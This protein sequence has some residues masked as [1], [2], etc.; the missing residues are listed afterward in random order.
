MTLGEIV[1]DDAPQSGNWTPDVDDDVLSAFL[2]A[3]A[4]A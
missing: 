3:R 2:A 4:R 1:T